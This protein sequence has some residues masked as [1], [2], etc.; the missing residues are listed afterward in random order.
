MHKSIIQVGV[1]VGSIIAISAAAFAAPIKNGQYQ[2]KYPDNVGIKI[3]NKKFSI[4][5]DDTAPDPA[6]IMPKGDFKY[7][8]TGTFYLNKNKKYYCLVGKAQLQTKKIST[9]FTCTR[10]GW[11]KIN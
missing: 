7:V 8:N 4:Y 2:T 10:S 6:K 9:R 1:L 3:D 11:T 5:Y